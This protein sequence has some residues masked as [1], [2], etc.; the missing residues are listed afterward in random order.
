M[1]WAWS[2]RTRAGVGGAG[3]AGAGGSHVGERAHMTGRAMDP[4]PSPAVAAAA[5]AEADEEA[6]PPATG[7]ARGPMA[8]CGEPSAS[9]SGTTCQCHTSP[10]RGGG[11]GHSWGQP[12]PAAP[13]DAALQ[14]SVSER[15]CGVAPGSFLTPLWRRGLESGL[16]SCVTMSRER[17]VSLV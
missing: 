10:G 7:R 4:L 6:D 8:L 1:V 2:R 16:Y 15:P 3:R 5:E 13:W 17:D 12:L 11:G 9:H 14:P